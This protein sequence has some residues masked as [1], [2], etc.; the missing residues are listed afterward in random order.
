MGL[1]E[2]AEPG[3]GAHGLCLCANAT[4]LEAGNAVADFFDPGQ[5]TVAFEH[6]QNLALG[7]GFAFADTQFLDDAAIRCL[8]DLG[9]VLRNDLT[10]RP[11][12]L[13]DFEPGSPR[14][15]QDQEEQQVNARETKRRVG[16][17]HADVAAVAVWVLT[18][19]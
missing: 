19:C 13:V 5:G 17:A 10:L 11:D 3:H 15:E 4:D 14:H 7:D 16:V 1:V 6:R 18:G 9:F 12:H 8:D 2:M